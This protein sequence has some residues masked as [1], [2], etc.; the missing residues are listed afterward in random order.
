MQKVRA[1]QAFLGDNHQ[2]ISIESSNTS[3]LSIF[4]MV[5]LTKNIK[6]ILQFLRNKGLLYKEIKGTFY[7]SLR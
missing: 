6:D 4:D 5:D 7:N 2:Q 1:L 3:T